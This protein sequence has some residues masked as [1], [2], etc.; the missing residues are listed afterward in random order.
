MSFIIGSGGGGGSD[1]S[2]AIPDTIVNFQY[3]NDTLTTTQNPTPNREFYSPFLINSSVIIRS[4]AK[5]INGLT[6]NPNGKYYGS[7]Y[8]YDKDTG[9]LNLV[10]VQ[11]TEF[12]YLSGS[13]S[14]GW[15]IVNLTAP[16]ELDSG[17]Y[18]M[19]GICDST[20]NVIFRY[21]QLYNPLAGQR[22][23]FIA[24]ATGY[25]RTGISYDFGSTPTT[26]P[27]SALSISSSQ[28]VPGH[29]FYCQI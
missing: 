11:P 26:I 14:T 2:I 9:N 24:G 5:Y 19:R 3:S 21:Q 10:A 12:D 22:T 23:I 18:F 7:I 16:V 17:L 20:G 28:N 15:Q 29:A 4:F 1:Y 6:T 25:E 8:K 13:G 27:F